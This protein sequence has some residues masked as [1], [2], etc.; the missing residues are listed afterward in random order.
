VK[1]LHGVFLV[2]LACGVPAVAAGAARGDELEERLAMIH[3]RFVSGR[4]PLYTADFIL[5]DVSLDPANRRWF[6]NFSG[7]ETGR[8]LTMLAM[9][10]PPH[11]PIER[12]AFLARTV[13]YQRS[14]GRFGDSTVSFVGTD[15]GEPQMSLLWG[16]GRLL[17]GLMDYYSRFGDPAA[18]A[19]AVK[20]AAFIARITEVCLRPEAVEKLKHGDA[21]GYIC[22]TQTVEGMAKLYAA[23]RDTAYL[24][25]A[26]EAYRH[27]PEMGNQHTHG[28]LNTLRGVALLYQITKD[29]VHL[30]FVT[31]RFDE[32]LSS[33]DH[34]IFGGTSEYFGDQ[35]LRAYYHD[36]GCSLGDFIMLCLQLWEITGKRRYLEEGEY[37]LMNQFFHNQFYSGDFG[38]HQIDTAYGF[39]LES[40]EA[41]AWWCCNY[42]CATTLS[43]VRDRIITPLKDGLRVNLFFQSA[44][45]RDGLDVEWRK[46]TSRTGGLYLLKIRKADASPHTI[47]VR[48]P[49]WAASISA[50]IG[51]VP[52]RGETRDGYMVFTRRWRRGELLKIS[53]VYRVSFVRRNDRKVLSSDEMG[54]S[55]ITAALRYGPYLMSV[56]DGFQPLYVAAPSW[57]H[58]IVVDRESLSGGAPQTGTAPGGSFVPEAYLRFRYRHWGMSPLQEVIMRPM[59]EDTFQR[60]ANLRVWFQFATDR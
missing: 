51:G 56:D 44:Y 48:V 28:Y 46:V 16:N 15:L 58:V 30:D 6:T 31:Q 42:H 4:T 12:T 18:L 27:L 53:V 25:N 32:V 22:F 23:T 47:A 11:N 20:L 52:S 10:P 8:Y 60:P 38:H 19:S 55:E 36:E 14:D 43:Y 26:T 29:P 13:S 59:S 40:S 39:M 2:A 9:S 7:D 24:H 41:R 57:G 33:K 3:R 17:A 49:G 54:G 37:C 5:A 45:R 21:A 35:S 34:L 1:V 50:S